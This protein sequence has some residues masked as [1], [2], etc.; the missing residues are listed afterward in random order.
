MMLIDKGYF[1]YDYEQIARE[2]R[3]EDTVKTQEE[4]DEM[5][6]GFGFG[7]RKKAPESLEEIQDHILKHI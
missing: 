7:G 5:L 1:D 3:W 2:A 6:K 4:L